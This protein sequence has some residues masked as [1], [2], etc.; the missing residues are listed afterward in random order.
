MAGV[1]S[2]RMHWIFENSLKSSGLVNFLSENVWQK[3]GDW[4]FTMAQKW[5]LEGIAQREIQRYHE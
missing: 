5:A 2:L 1:H 3:E 4:F